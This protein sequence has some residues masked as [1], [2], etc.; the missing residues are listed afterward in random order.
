MKIRARAIIIQD[1]KILLIK[2]TKPDEVYF[3]IPGG[4]VE[5]NETMEEALVRECREELG[6]SIK[7]GLKVSEL[8]SKKPETAGHSE[9]FFICDIESGIL[10]SG[11]GPEF[12][13]NTSYCGGYQ[14]EWKRL[15][16]LLKTNLKPKEIKDLIY[17]KYS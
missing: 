8:I 11:Q 5:A 16:D 17:K 7:V 10:G 9:H 1:G 14:L 12:Q 6:V 15:Q 2:R 4:G 13:I 3:V